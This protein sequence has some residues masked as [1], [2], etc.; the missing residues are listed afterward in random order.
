MSAFDDHVA[1]RAAGGVDGGDGRK[2]LAISKKIMQ[3]LNAS[4]CSLLPPR[5]IATFVRP[6]G[7]RVR[8]QPKRRPKSAAMA[9]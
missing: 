5:A 9:T 3:N 8:V 4:S 2:G 7:T 1:L 6:P